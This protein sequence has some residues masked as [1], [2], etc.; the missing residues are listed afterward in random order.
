MLSRDWCQLVSAGLFGGREHGRIDETGAMTLVAMPNTAVSRVIVRA[1]SVATWCDDPV[2]RRHG[3]SPW[4]RNRRANRRR[5][6]DHRVTA[7]VIVHR[8]VRHRRLRTRRSSRSRTLLNSHGST[9]PNNSHVNMSNGGPDLPYPPRKLEA[10][11]ERQRRQCWKRTRRNSTS[12]SPT[13]PL[14]ARAEARDC[15]PY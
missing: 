5:A 2:R 4:S 7:T 12:M 8:W 10:R 1:S 3:R 13:A 11:D 14:T 9:S 15:R 6:P